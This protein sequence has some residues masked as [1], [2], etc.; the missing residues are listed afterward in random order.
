MEQLNRAANLIVLQSQCNKTSNGTN[1][2]NFV[3]FFL[4][5]LV[6]RLPHY[7][8]IHLTCFSHVI[9]FLFGETNSRSV[10]TFESLRQCDFIVCNWAKWKAEG[11][12]FHLKLMKEEKKYQ[13]KTTTKYN[14][15]LILVMSFAYCFR[16]LSNF[17]IVSVIIEISVDKSIYRSK[18]LGK[19]SMAKDK[20]KSVTQYFCMT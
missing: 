3:S 13:S 12:I 15:D 1:S 2:P 17:V 9:S 11:D 6:H 10:D 7:T 8:L 14:P 18:P 4:S 5:F 20:R 16:L 19:Q